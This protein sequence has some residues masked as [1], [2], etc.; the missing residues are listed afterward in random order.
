MACLPSLP[1]LLMTLGQSLPRLGMTY[2]WA[3][4]RGLFVHGLFVH[5]L[6]GLVFII[7]EH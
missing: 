5:G 4:A 2:I 6:K 1:A 7:L 3:Q